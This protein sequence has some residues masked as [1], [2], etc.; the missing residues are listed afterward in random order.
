MKTKIYYFTGSGNSLY[1]TRELA[2]KIGNCEVLSM[3]HSLKNPDPVAGESIGLVFPVY[4]YRLPRLVKEFI[5]KIKSADYIFA[6]ANNAGEMG[7]SLKQANCLLKR[8]GLKL[9]AGYSLKMPSNYTPWGGA[10]PAEEQREHFESAQNKLDQIAKNT[11]EL[12]QHIES[13]TPWHKVYLI[14]GVVYK[15][16]Y[17]FIPTQDKSFFSDESCNHC[18]ICEKIC[19]VNNITMDKQRPKWNHQCQMCFACMQWC[20]QSAIQFGRATINKIRYKNPFVDL[21]DILAQ[22]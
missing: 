13:E 6:L 10:I 14:P 3:V 22:K 1:L 15:L 12:Y 4:M 11:R 9:N 17:Q 18:G 5:E 2:E 7:K 8:S 21:K 19:P 20:P 16:G